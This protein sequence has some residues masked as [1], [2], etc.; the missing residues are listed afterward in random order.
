MKG[1]IHQLG[2]AAIMLA[3]SLPAQAKDPLAK[4][5]GTWKIQA[6]LG[7]GAAGSL[8]DREARQLIG[9]TFLIGTKRF[10]F[11]GRPCTETRYEETVED[12]DAHFEREWNTTVKDVPLP[13]PLTVIDTGCN[14]LYPLKSGKLMVAEKGVFFE[15]ARMKRKGSR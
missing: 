1:R 5:H 12:K 2:H 14:I 13:D 9:K 11:N 15:A 4:L 3:L 8:S 10:T 6:I 7:S